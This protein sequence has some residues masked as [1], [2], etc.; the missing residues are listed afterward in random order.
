MENIPSDGRNQATENLSGEAARRKRVDA[1]VRREIRLGLLIPIVLLAAVAL[2]GVFLRD[3]INAFASWVF[4][5]LGF[6]G[7]AVVFFV[8]ETVVSP[9]PPDLI[10][11]IVASSDLSDAWEA[12]VAILALLSTLGGH[13]GWLLGWRLAEAGL[14]RRVLG[15]HHGRSLAVMQRYG[16]W[17]VVLAALTPLPW[18]VTSWTAGALR[19]PWRL[20][21]LGSL[22]RFPRVVVY[23]VFIHAAYHGV[24]TPLT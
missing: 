19:M 7:L 22:T 5:H 24:A 14:V 21:L 8:S 1:L 9:L 10:L 4:Y 18:S 23:Y 2:S 12:P 13:L 17:A 16:V 6:G 11:L 3:E 15:R 20:Y